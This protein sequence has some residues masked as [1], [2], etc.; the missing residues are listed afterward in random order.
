MSEAH[1]FY[2]RG[3]AWEK[4]LEGV[5]TC[6]PVGYHTDFLWVVY[7]DV[8][9]PCDEQDELGRGGSGLTIM[10]AG[11]LEGL[12]NPGPLFWCG[13]GPW[14]GTLG[15]WIGGS[16]HEIGH[17]LGLPHPPGC[18]EEKPTC[19][20]RALMWFGFEEYPATYLRGDEKAFLRGV[21][22]IRR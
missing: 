9:E 21:D 20:A 3:D 2:A 7:T 19:D 4:V 6:G 14:P 17:A 16:G 8:K 13:N 18:E 12:T 1:D 22:F 5:Q 10:G 15:R 11:D